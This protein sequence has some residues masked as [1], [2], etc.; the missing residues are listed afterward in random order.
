MAHPTALSG[1][2]HDMHPSPE[3]KTL[4]RIRAHERERLTARA[5][6]AEIMSIGLTPDL[7]ERARLFLEGV[8]EES[9]A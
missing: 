9:A 5:L 6:L 3:A 7:Q 2:G 4:T 8:P 1:D